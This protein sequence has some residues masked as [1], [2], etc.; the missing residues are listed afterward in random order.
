MALNMG[1]F[2]QMLKE[3]YLPVINQAVNRPWELEILRLKA[4]IQR[5]EKKVA[6]QKAKLMRASRKI[7]RMMASTRYSAHCGELAEDPQGP[8]ILHEEL[9]YWLK[10]DPDMIGEDGIHK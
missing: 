7:G 10:A 3:Q 1:L 4:E 8:F 5:L 2:G 9:E 6:R